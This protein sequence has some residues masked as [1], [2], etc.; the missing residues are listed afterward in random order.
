MH[1]PILYGLHELILNIFLCIGFLR[2]PKS[3]RPDAIH[4]A[5]AVPLLCSTNYLFLLEVEV[6]L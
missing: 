1:K 5:D 2:R 3:I 4:Q 6:A